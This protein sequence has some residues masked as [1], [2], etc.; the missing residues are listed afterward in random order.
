[1]RI[2]L[3]SLLV[4]IISFETS[5]STIKSMSLVDAIDDFTYA[6]TVEWDQKDQGQYQSIKDRFQK[7]MSDIMVKEGL[8]SEQV[9]VTIRDAISDKKVAQEIETKLSMIPDAEK[10]N[11]LQQLITEQ[12]NHLYKKGASWNG[13]GIM[14]VGILVGALA[15]LAVLALVSAGG[16]KGDCH[17]YEEQE[18]YDVVSGNY[19]TTTY[20]AEYA[21][22]L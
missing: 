4:F 11:F 14:A 21:S 2:F 16:G 20:C 1:M 5:A 15:L 7:S 18:H 12:N 8:S 10:I 9:I 19:Y 17:N 22:N 13:E 6:L 3:A